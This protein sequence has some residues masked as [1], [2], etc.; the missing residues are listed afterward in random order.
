MSKKTLYAFIISFL[1]LIAVIVLNRFSFDSM[2]NFSEEVDRTRQ[3]ISVFEK[4]S[5]HL[6]SAQI[7]TP[8]Y[9]SIPER[10]FYK[11]YRSEAIGIKAELSQ[12]K[13]LVSDNPEQIKRVDTL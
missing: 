5:D 7:Y 4:I 1:L 9:D 8:I 10:D 6:K 11:L 2:R 3:V 13:K 12:L